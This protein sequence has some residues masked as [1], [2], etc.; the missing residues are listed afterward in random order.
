MP[1]ELQTL[2]SDDNVFE[3]ST[4]SGFAGTKLDEY[5][6][7]RQVNELTLCGIDTDQCVLATAFSAFDLGYKVNV[8]F[9][10][11][12]STNNLE[13]HAQAIIRKK[14]FTSMIISALLMSL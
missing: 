4:Y 8:N 13:E 7:N 11:T 2:A 6:K 12:F 9:D 1:P 10:L 14:L 5:L 3:K